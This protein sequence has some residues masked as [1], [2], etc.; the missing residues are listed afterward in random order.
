LE[1]AQEPEQDPEVTEPAGPESQATNNVSEITPETKAIAN[2]QPEKK[3]Q[4][5]VA[6]EAM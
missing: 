4:V 6:T 5:T 2:D 3:S 1:T